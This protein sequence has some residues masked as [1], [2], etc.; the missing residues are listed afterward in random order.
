MPEH[1]QHDEHWPPVDPNLADKPKDEHAAGNGEHHEE[2]VGILRRIYALIPI[3]AVLFLSYQAFEYLVVALLVPHTPPPQITRIPA[4]LTAEV[5]QSKPERWLGT[6]VAESP[7][8][9][10]AHY[11][12]IDGWFQPDEVNGCTQSGCHNAMPHAKHKEDRAFLNMHATSLHC[13]VCHMNAD[14]RPL[15]LVWYDLE[16]GHV[17]A[18]PAL[19]AA[20]GFV[21]SEA[22]RDAIDN[23]THETQLR[24]VQLL[25][26]AAREADGDPSLQRLAKRVAAPRYSSQQFKNILASL[27]TQLPRHFRGEYGSKLALRDP[28]TGRPILNH[29]NSADAIRAYLAL[30]ESADA[31]TRDAA[32][33]RVHTARRPE[34]LECTA[35]HQPDSLV[36]LAVVGYPPERIA[37]LQQGFIFGAIEHIMQ[38]R[39]LHLPGF[40][41]PEEP[42]NAVPASED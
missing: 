1:D 19:L 10:L 11:H 18:P 2:H 26:L 38:G 42:T 40:I 6:A 3:V 30:D 28:Q 24:M 33:D 8:T 25:N 35:C 4:R 21:M 14:T 36:D 32:L 31:A 15:P 37:T 5:W 41:S 20:Y 13:S 7:R 39:P 29:P 17:T 9:P 12:H 22:G 27:R 23:P 16:D 34:T